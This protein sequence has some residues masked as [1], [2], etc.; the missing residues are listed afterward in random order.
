MIRNHKYDVISLFH[1]PPQ[2]SVLEYVSALPTNCPFPAKTIT[3]NNCF[4]LYM[5]KLTSNVS[6]LYRHDDKMFTLP[7]ACRPPCSH[8]LSHAALQYAIDHRYLSFVDDELGGIGFLYNGVVNAFASC[9]HCYRGILPF[10][11]C[12][13]ITSYFFLCCVICLQGTIIVLV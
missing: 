8:C 4:C 12:Y 6:M 2:R 7:L 3:K 5:G 10:W 11:N 1:R 9:S 13:N